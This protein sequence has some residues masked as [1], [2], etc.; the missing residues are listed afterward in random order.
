V[1]AVFDAERS[2]LS[3]GKK[4]GKRVTIPSLGLK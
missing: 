4:K 2:S 1:G 3:L